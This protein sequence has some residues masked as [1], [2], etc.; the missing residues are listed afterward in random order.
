MED[1]SKKIR[2]LLQTQGVPYT[3]AA[4]SLGLTEDH[5]QDILD[6]NE[7]PSARVIRGL[8]ELC[9]V[10]PEF[11][12]GKRQWSE[13]Q[14]GSRAERKP[15]DSASGSR[16]ERKS[17]PDPQED[18]SRSRGPLTLKD[19]AVRFQA[20]VECL[21]EQEV[22][23]PALFKQK[24]DEVEARTHS[25]VERKD[26]TKEKGRLRGAKTPLEKK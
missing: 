13:M 26:R 23:S 22:L 20:L 8:A 6:G 19:L 10:K 9:S 16:A 5:F 7:E 12:A 21:V 14:S 2:F 24:T 15:D 3:R 1:I 25:R 4:E 17:A 11:L 18:S